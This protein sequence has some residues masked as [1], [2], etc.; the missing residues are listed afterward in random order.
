MIEADGVHAPVEE[1]LRGGPVLGPALDRQPRSCGACSA[2]CFVLGVQPLNKPA[3]Q[4]CA[5]ACEKGCGIY[6]TRPEPCRLYRCG[7]LEGFGERRD[8]PD[9][10]GV[11]LDR[12]APPAEL[13][14]RAAA[15]DVD[16]I[17]KCEHAK[18]T[19]R[20]REVRPG[21]LGVARVKR[22]L[23][24]LHRRGHLVALV[25]FAGRRLPVGKPLGAKP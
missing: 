2:C 14:A 19:I 20:A 16:A 12:I 21:A 25:P 1:E 13:Q 5:H 11:I 6:E 9:R 18:R 17:A 8:R 22:F 4:R 24:G 23:E 7:W 15:G 10:L 3:F